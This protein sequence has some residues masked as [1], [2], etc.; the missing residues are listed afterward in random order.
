VLRVTVLSTDTARYQPVVTILDSSNGEVSCGV[1]ALGRPGAA[2]SATAYVTPL[3]ATTPQV[4]LVR[5]AQV[6]NS[7]PSGGLPTL[8]VRVAGRD[9]TAPHIVVTSPG[10][11]QPKS[12][13]V[14]DAEQTSDAASGVDRSSA[15][16]QFYDH[17]DGRDVSRTLDGMRVTYHWQSTGPRIVVFD[18][19]DLAGN[20]SMYR[21]TTLVRDT[22]RPSVA[23]HLTPP[24]PGARTLHI[25]VKASESVSVR[26]LVT[27]AG[28]TRPLLQKSLTFWGTKRHPRA[29]R[30]NRPV[31]KGLMVFGG[32]AR[33]LSGN[34]I[35]LPQCVVDPV[36]G[37]GSCITP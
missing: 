24:E 30:L 10:T 27:Q 16:W 19:K 18:V 14:Y 29:I 32:I 26:L 36:T 4:Y 20:E 15:H 5:V 34:A 1:A 28:R 31:R 3:N 6:M 33:D 12:A 35:A 22:V 7:S 8:T 17:I 2:A 9:V 13:T 21:F 11:V 23:F 37:Q 25:I